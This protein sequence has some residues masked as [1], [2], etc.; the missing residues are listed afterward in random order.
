VR[1][2]KTIRSAS[3]LPAFLLSI[4]FLVY[5][6]QTLPGQPQLDFRTIKATSS[7]VTLEFFGKC[8]GNI[9][10]NFTKANL[11]VTENGT[12][13]SDFTLQHGVPDCCLSVALVFDRSG[14]MGIGT[15]SPMEMTKPAG[16]AFVD[17][18]TAPGAAAMKRRSSVLTSR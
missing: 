13:V 6:P 2:E 15:P 11:R 3:S 9:V 4:L 7:Q 10:Y 14:S 8:G 12:E 18:M 16:K 17:K 5:N 1:N